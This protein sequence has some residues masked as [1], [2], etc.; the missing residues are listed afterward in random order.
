MEI[1]PL[2]RMLLMEYLAEAQ[3]KE[4]KTGG[5]QDGGFAVLLA[6]TLAGGGAKLP[7]VSP[8]II[9]NYKTTAAQSMTGAQNR[10]VSGVAAF[11]G[12][13][14]SGGARSG[15]AVAG[16]QGLI[17]SVAG[18][19][20]VDPALVKSVIKAESNFDPG[21]TSAAGAMGL[22]QLMPGTAASLGVQNAY[23]P[24]QNLE[25]GVRYLKQMLDR[26]SGDPSLALAAYNAGPGAVDQ[27]GG[28]PNYRETRDYIRKVLENRI[29]FTV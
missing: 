3:G 20:G 21:A 15:V 25:G 1:N 24:V 29:D 14:E 7:P 26:Y 13:V 28:I 6:L 10:R 4:N 23:D 2:V 19:Y 11:H 8:G 18:R 27:A 17:E 5:A 9:G 16:L 22:M 12:Q